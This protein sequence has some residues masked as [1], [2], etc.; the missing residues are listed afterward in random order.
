M[1][2]VTSIVVVLNPKHGTTPATVSKINPIPAQTR[3]LA[4][5]WDTNRG[6]RKRHGG[7][8]L[9]A[10][11]AAPCPWALGTPGTRG[12]VTPLGWWCS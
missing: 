2:Y 5:H 8:G 1:G 11:D 12:G 6:E 10:P 9:A 4:Q 3:R 7:G